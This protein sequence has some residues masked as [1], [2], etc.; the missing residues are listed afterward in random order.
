M[1][2]RKSL[3]LRHFDYTGTSW[4]FVTIKAFEDR[5]LFSEITDEIPRLSQ[6]GAIV[7]E[8]WK[9]LPRRLSCI[10]LDECVVMP[11]HFHGILMIESPGSSRVSKAGHGLLHAS[12]GSVISQFKSQ[13]V[14]RVRRRINDHTIDLWQRN[15]YESIIQSERDLE[16]VRRYIRENPVR[17]NRSQ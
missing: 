14:K 16:R 4:Y 8:E 1:Q 2:Q 3:R 5:M 13:T 7:Q 15:Y 12:L 17:W 10:R 6:I 11:N 9:R